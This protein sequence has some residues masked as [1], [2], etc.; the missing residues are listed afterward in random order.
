[1][2]GFAR[3]IRESMSKRKLSTPNRSSCSMAPVFTLP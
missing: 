1:M 3:S 2:L